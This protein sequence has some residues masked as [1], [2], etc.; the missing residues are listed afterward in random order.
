MRHGGW[1]H[2]SLHFFRREKG[3]YEGVI[4]ESLKV[5]G[6]VGKIESPIVHY[7]F[8]SFSQLIHRHNWYSLKEAEEEYAKHGEIEPSRLNYEL[9]KKPLKRFFKF[10]VKKKGFLEGMHGFLFS[11]LFAWVHFLNWAKYWELCQSKKAGSA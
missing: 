9:K 4:H 8:T 5:D 3:R 6:T 2:Y 7:P 1:F 11:V 10:Y